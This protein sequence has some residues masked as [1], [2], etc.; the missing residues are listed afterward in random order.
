MT[1]P[2]RRRSP[3]EGAVFF[4]TGKDRWVARALIDGKCRKVFLR[5]RQRP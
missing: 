5:R 2:G 1:D 4:D 3:G